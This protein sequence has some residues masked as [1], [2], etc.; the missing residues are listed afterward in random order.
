MTFAKR[1]KFKDATGKWH[2]YIAIYVD[3]E[4]LQSDWEAI[5]RIKNQG[6]ED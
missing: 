2:S 5:Q 1:V 6:K 3:G 4:M